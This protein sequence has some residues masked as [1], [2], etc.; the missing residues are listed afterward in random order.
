MHGTSNEE[1]EY[2]GAVSD[3]FLIKINGMTKKNTDA[4]AGVA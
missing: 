2:V 4:K 1:L 3:K